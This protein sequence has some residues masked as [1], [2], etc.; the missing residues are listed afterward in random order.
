M[1]MAPEIMKGTEYDEKVD[2]YSFS[3]LLITILT[4]KVIHLIYLSSYYFLILFFC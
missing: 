4:R 3:M 1:Y 2:V